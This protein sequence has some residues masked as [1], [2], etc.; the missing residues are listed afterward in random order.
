MAIDDITSPPPDRWFCTTSDLDGLCGISKTTRTNRLNQLGFTSEWLHKD[1]RKYWLTEEQYQAFT[2]FI[3]YI[4][5]TGSHEGYPKLPQERSERVIETPAEDLAV[6]VET[7]ADELDQGTSGELAIATESL[8]E[9]P[10]P[11]LAGEFTQSVPA[12]NYYSDLL[13]Q[14]I[15]QNA[16]NRAAGIL[17]AEQTIANEYI[18]NPEALAPELRAKIDALQIPSID[19]NA[20]A[21]SLVSGV[22]RRLANGLTG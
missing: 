1:G 11:T 10:A 20:L 16:Q 7:V 22:K 2:E 15:T 6:A 21:A 13:I 8:P 9:L 12:N 19:P 3:A 17:I 5:Q 14:Q 18:Q 4:K